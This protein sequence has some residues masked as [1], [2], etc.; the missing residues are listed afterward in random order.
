MLGMFSGPGRAGSAPQGWQLDYIVVLAL[1]A[2][3]LAR[4][5]SVDEITAPAREAVATWS[6]H[7]LPG[8]VADRL[9]KLVTCPVCV[10]WWTSLA[11]SLSVPGH[12]KLQ[13]GVAVAGAQV[14]MT[15]AER[16]V[17]ERGRAAIEE[18]DIAATVNELG[19]N[20]AGGI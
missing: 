19:P 15:L 16:L 7:H 5:V 4:A 9:Q 11:M 14:L 20:G 1:G 6:A 17:S 2:N 12:R 8:P 13:R 10:G 3:R 18:A